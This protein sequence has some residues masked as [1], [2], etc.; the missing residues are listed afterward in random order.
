MKTEYKNENGTR[1]E[2]KEEE[3]RK[4]DEGIEER[5][6]LP[7]AARDLLPGPRAILIPPF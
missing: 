6:F 3:E 4:A 7:P 2:P 1:E 5:N